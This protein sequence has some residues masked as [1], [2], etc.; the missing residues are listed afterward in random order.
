MAV[1][2]ASIA[3]AMLAGIWNARDDRYSEQ[4]GEETANRRG[5]ADGKVEMSY[6]GG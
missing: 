3:S 1:V 4:R 6:I 2:P 5:D